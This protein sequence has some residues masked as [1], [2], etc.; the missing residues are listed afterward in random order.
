MDD[1]TTAT[2]A[3]AATA[4]ATN[5]RAGTGFFPIIGDAT[6]VRGAE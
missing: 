5:A 3:T 4:A 6:D 2:A 1:G